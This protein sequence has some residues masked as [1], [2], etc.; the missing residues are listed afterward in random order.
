MGGTKVFLRSNAYEILER[1]RVET[2]GKSAIFIQAGA[3]RFN[4]MNR[5]NKMKT[6]IIIIQSVGR[7]VIA[8]QLL[9]KKRQYKASII[10]QK[11][12]RSLLARSSF[13]KMKYVAL[14]CQKYQ[15]GK[16]QR[17][18]FTSLLEQYRAVIIIQVN[19]ECCYLAG[20]CFWNR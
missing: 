14:W 8:R 3:R 5:Y 1:L 19:L 2:L 7:V 18:R 13:L 20:F 11:Y 10:V 16:T 17:K 6:S 15:K 9:R 12:S 4:A